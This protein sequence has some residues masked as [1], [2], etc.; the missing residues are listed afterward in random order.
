MTLLAIDGPAGAGKTTFA[1]KLAEEFSHAASVQIIHMDDLYNGWDN[2]LSSNL[3]QILKGILLAHKESNEF[4]VQK[5][6]WSNLKRT[7]MQK[8]AA[9][10]VLIL[11]GVGA[12]QAIVRAAGATTYWIDIERELGLQRVLVRDGAQIEARMRQWLIDQEI[13]FQ[14]DQT[15]E[16]CKHRITS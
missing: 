8:I 9:T 13:Y 11:E 1:A 12:A 7:K 2:A 16:N 3:T 5:I 4:W 14:S 6:N 10:D 15:R